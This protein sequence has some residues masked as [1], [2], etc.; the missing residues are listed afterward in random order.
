MSD[1]HKVIA[2]PSEEAELVVSDKSIEII[3]AEA[4]KRV[5][6]LKK[7]LGVAIKRT[8]PSDWV[9]Q[10]GKPYLG[11]SGCE[12]VAPLFGLKM[13]G[14]VSERSEREDDKGKYY[15]Y[16]FMGRFF[17]AAGD[18][19]AIGT[20]SSRDKFFGWQ[21]AKKENGEIIEQA[22]YKPLHDVDE[23]NIKKA[24][25]SNLI[26]NGVTRALGIR[27]LAWSDLEPYGIKKDQCT[28]VEYNKGKEGESATALISE[29]QVKRFYSIAKS[30]G[31]GDT[32]LKEWLLKEYKLDSATKIT[33]KDKQYENII[34][35]VQ[36]AKGVEPGA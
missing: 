13:E 25:Y 33:W 36:K 1:E 32:E 24:A 15:F 10:N 12:K 4:E 35:A 34:I 3:V 26:V 29:A 14:V 5:S 27:S 23:T 8:N 2:V 17:W 22:G 28:K 6:V 20:C 19:E 30:C 11:A 9:D 31:W 18:I 7:I 16:T 21:S